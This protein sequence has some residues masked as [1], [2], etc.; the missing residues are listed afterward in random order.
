MI[1][2]ALKFQS[3]LD[4]EALQELEV[5]L[6]NQLHHGCSEEAS[7]SNN[8]I[9]QDQLDSRSSES[10][11]TLSKECPISL[12]VNP[13]IVQPKLFPPTKSSFQPRKGNIS[14]RYFNY[15]NCTVTNLTKVNSWRSERKSPEMNFRNFT[16]N[17]IQNFLNI[18]PIIQITTP[19]VPVNNIIILHPNTIQPVS[20]ASPNATKLKP[21]SP[22]NIRKRNR[23][24]KKRSEAAQSKQN[25]IIIDRESGNADTSLCAKAYT[26]RSP[27]EKV[28]AH[29]DHLNL[30]NKNECKIPD[31]S[32][33]IGKY[34]SVNP[35]EHFNRNQRKSTNVNKSSSNT[36]VSTFFFIWSIY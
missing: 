5:Q 13:S 9:I 10:H 21:K 20:T 33:F 32:P 30:Q 29:F 23:R 24:R 25:V 3:D 6:Y 35:K 12:A 11:P 15:N 17:M 18:S 26:S 4:Y 31:G 28:N 7:T 8:T 16:P 34:S 22:S 36:S 14:K 19:Q 1:N 27:E 2:V